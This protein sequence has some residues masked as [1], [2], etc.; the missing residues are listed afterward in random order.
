MNGQPFEAPQI[1]PEF[2]SPRKAR[3]RKGNGGKGEDI[4]FE[5]TG[6]GMP[7]FMLEGSSADEPEPVAMPPRLAGK[8]G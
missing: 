8:K 6:P 3:K 2:A 1:P 4:S 7:A 5:D